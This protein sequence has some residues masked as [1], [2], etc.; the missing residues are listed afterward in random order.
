MRVIVLLCVALTAGLAACGQSGQSNLAGGPPE[1]A[2]IRGES[3]AWDRLL[4]DETERLLTVQFTGGPE[5]SLTKPCNVAYEADAIESPDRIVITV[6]RRQ[7]ASPP[8]ED[9]LCNAAGHG[10]Q[11]AVSIQQP[12]GERSVVDGHTETTHEPATGESGSPSVTAMT[13]QET[14]TT[15]SA[16]VNLSPEQQLEVWLSTVRYEPWYDGFQF[17]ADGGVL[18]LNPEVEPPTLPA[19]LPIRAITSRMGQRQWDQLLATLFDELNQLGILDLRYDPFADTVTV[20]MNEAADQ[21]GIGNVVDRVQSILGDPFQDISIRT[22]IGFDSEGS[23]PRT[24][25]EAPPTTRG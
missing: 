5:G 12:I 21:A 23:P 2:T 4:V 24:S 25:F 11:L 1:P 22:K 8:L 10:R 9:V 14:M 15:I 16:H 18:A 3:L 7:L 17:E 19:E 6:F 13:S 20:S